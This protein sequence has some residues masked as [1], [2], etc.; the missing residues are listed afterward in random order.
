[1]CHDNEERTK[2]WRG[3]DLF[4]KTDMRNLTSF[5]TNTQ[6]S[7]KFAVSWAL[8]LAKYICL[9]LKNYRGIMFDSTEDWCKIWRKTDLRFEKWHEEF[10]K[11][12][13]TAK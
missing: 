11:F 3:I 4:F 13:H 8:F 5:D 6:K 2:I 1:M 7:Q 12:S 10:G 9:E